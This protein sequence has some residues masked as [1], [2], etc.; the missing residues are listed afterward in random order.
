MKTVKL[1]GIL[2]FATIL[3]A[4]SCKKEQTT[5]EQPKLSTEAEITAFKLVSGEVSYD[6]FIYTDKPVIEISYKAKDYDALKSA[7]AEVTI[8]DKATIS[9]DP[10]VETD[11][12][13][14]D[15]VVYTVTAEDGTT[16]TEYTVTIIEATQVVTCNE[17][18]NKTYGAIGLANS[19]FNN[20]AI[21]FSGN[22]IVMHDATVID[23]S[24]NSVGKV[25]L[26]GVEAGD[27]DNFQFACLSSDANGVLVGSIGLTSDGA[28]AVNSD[29]IAKTRIYAWLDGYDKA[30][31]LIKQSD[32]YNFALY[33]SV[34]G[35]IKGKGILNYIAPVRGA[36][37]MHHVY[38]T[39]TGDWEN[40]AW[41]GPVVNLPSNDG[42]WGQLI[43]FASGDP[44]GPMFICD[45]QGNNQGM[46]IY[47]REGVNGT[48]DT[49]LYGTLEDDG[50]LETGYGGTYQYGNYSTG[51]IRAFMF[52]GKPYV[53]V[54]SSGWP[55]AYLTIQPAD[56]NADYLLRS[57][58][59]EAAACVPCSAYYA[60]PETGK[61]YV[62][63]TAQSY[64][65]ALYEISVE[66]I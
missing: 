33:M 2:A 52:E 12:T 5:E 38:Y 60:D 30:P 35:D 16:K 8:S 45:S 55:S 51:H 32:E 20:G 22:H 58:V 40:A 44:F 7:V 57:V 53:S 31:T 34:A 46:G 29:G 17:V 6:G 49:P 21:A 3:L 37:Q 10:T 13:V 1:F 19:I 28:L 26:T 18:W 61:S 48:V 4:V 43:S 9:P 56:Q 63:F 36:T 25:N 54:S 65:V 14:A 64:F 24:G 50:I 62:A 11:Y 15:G 27:S 47:Y 59:Y 39:E 42:N 23:L 66:Y 41:A